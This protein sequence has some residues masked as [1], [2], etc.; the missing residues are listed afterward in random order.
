MIE[1]IPRV[2]YLQIS[3]CVAL[4]NYDINTIEENGLEI[5]VFLFIK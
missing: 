3:T 1:A 2:G 4:Y 5:Y